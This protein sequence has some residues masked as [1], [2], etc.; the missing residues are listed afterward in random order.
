MGRTNTLRSFQ[1]IT[2]GD[3]SGDIT[4]AVTHIGHLTNIGLQLIWSGTVA[5]SLIVQVSLDYAQDTQGNVTNTG[6]WS[7]VLLSSDQSTAL[8][9]SN[10]GDAYIDLSNLAA[11]WIRVFYDSTSGSGALQGYISG[12]AA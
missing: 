7:D 12:K 4:S 10:S 1:N 8:T 11:P 5:G 2:D 6:T 9:V 3:M